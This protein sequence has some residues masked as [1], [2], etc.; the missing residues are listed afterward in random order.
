M[1]GQL[2]KAG[3]IC[4][5]VLMF[6]AFIAQVAGA[7][8]YPKK[9]IVLVNP[10]DVGGTTDLLMRC[11]M[12]VATSYLEQPFVMEIKAGG[13]GAIGSDYVAKAAPDGYTLLCGGT[14]SNSIPPAIMGRSKGPDDLDGVCQINYDSPF[15]FVRS[16]SAFKTFNDVIQYAKA[17]PNKL[18]TG[19]TGVW[20]AVDVAWKMVKR[21]TGIVTRD[22]PHQGG[23][24][25]ILALLGGQVDVVVGGYASAVPHI[26]AGKLRVLAYMGP[27]RFTE[28]PDVPTAKEQGINVTQIFRRSVMAPKG[29]PRPIINKLGGAFKKVTEDKS[30][31]AMIKQIGQEVNYLGPDEYSKAWREEYEEYKEL[32]KMFK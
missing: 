32:G 6:S 10:Y 1:K 4:L 16:D 15:V 8:D 23:G 29:T 22:V 25:T 26:K 5:V 24:Q 12:G 14:G 2:R 7:Q 28:L 9:P 20:G 18:V 19:H 31:I 17:N 27:E 3:W 11:V 21:Q 13:G 30:F